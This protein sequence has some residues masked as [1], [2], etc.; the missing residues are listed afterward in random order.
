VSGAA[1]GGDKETVAGQGHHPED[2]ITFAGHFEAAT[3]TTP[4]SAAG[5]LREKVTLA[6]ATPES[7]TSND[8]SRTATLSEEPP[9]QKTV[10]KPGNYSGRGITFSVAPGGTS[11]PPG[12]LRARLSVATRNCPLAATR[13]VLQRAT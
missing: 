7:C 1:D 8:Q 2:P 10:L 12:T 11:M 4:A 6:T 3:A 5:T 13:S 9:Q